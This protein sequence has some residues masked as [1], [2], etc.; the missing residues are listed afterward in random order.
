MT[1][2]VINEVQAWDIAQ[3][4]WVTAQML[5]CGSEYKTKP[6]GLFYVDIEGKIV[7]MIT[8]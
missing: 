7:W 1:C 5:K 6:S 8:G 2:N 3:H 4:R